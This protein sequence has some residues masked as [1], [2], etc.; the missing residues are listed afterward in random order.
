MIPLLVKLQLRRVV[1]L[2]QVFQ[3]ARK[4][5]GL[6]VRQIDASGRSRLEEDPPTRILEVWRV[7]QYVLV[8]GE[9]TLFSADAEGD[10]GACEGAAERKRG[11]SFMDKLAETWTF[12]YLL[13]TGWTSMYLDG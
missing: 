8:G 9:Q 5:F 4:D 10:Y 6:L 3:H 12:L 2:V 13:G 1:S 11:L 7:A